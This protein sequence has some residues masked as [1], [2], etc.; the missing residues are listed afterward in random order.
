MARPTEEDENANSDPF[1]CT[2]LTPEFMKKKE[3]T[4]LTNEERSLALQTIKASK[5]G[6]AVEGK[7]G[8]KLVWKTAG[9]SKNGKEWKHSSLV[10]QT[11][12]GKREFDN[13]QPQY[14][15]YTICTAP[16]N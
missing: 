6:I 5:D 7:E 2:P 13:K 12:N 8:W 10:L 11:V 14:R 4:P 9:K 16:G 1:L 15:T 3:E